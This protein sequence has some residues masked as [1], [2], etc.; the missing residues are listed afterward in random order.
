[1]NCSVCY[2]HYSVS[3]SFFSVFP[4]GAGVI[5]HGSV[6]NKSKICFPRRCGG[7]P[8]TVHIVGYRSLVFPAGAGVI[9]LMA[10]GL[11]R[12]LGFPRR[13]GGDPEKAFKKEV[14]KWFSP[15]VRG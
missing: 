9:L 8:Y 12:L 13:C 7:D 4:A 11:F 15:Q 1:M 14:R 5:P 10:L 6:H 3:T 2:E